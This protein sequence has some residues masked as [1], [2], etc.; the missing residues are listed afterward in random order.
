MK[1]VHPYLN[2]PGNAMEAFE[3]YRSVFGGEF[4]NVTRFRDMGGEQMGVAEED[5][6]KIANIGL[7]IGPNVVLMATD[8]VS[9]F[10][11]PL[12]VGN[13]SYIT[14]EPETSEEAE[15]VFAALSEGGR[16][17]M[18]MQQTEWA[19]SYGHFVDRFGVQWMVSYEGAVE[20][21]AGMT[22]TS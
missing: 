8:S 11:R 22:E 1:A 5:L 19:E 3:F 15:Q 7:P 9:S 21:T 6:D 2:F 13:N 17:E 12:Q 20:F 4:T 16:V 14:L 18:P 10:P